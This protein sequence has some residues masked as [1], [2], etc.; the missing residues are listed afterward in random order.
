[1]TVN[2]QE[3]ARIIKTLR[4]ERG[5]TQQELSDHSGVSV[6][7]IRYTENI[8]GHR[9]PASRTLKDLLTALGSDAGFLTGILAG[10]STATGSRPAPGEAMTSD[11][12]PGHGTGVD[13]EAIARALEPTLALRLSLDILDGELLPSVA[14]PPVRDA[15]CSIRR[16]VNAEELRQLRTY[17]LSRHYVIIKP[18]SPLA[19]PGPEDMKQIAAAIRTLDDL[20]LI[21]KPLD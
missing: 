21:I 12:D 18:I 1:M 15:L 10:P 5:W 8:T 7:V 2:W 6:A 11:N 19:P 17:G 16:W 9:R 14:T 4:K 3:A 13:I 20:G